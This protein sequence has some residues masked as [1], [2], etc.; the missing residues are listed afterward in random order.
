[1]QARNGRVLS[2]D[3]EAYY[4]NELIV[5]SAQTGAL[6][7]L[8]ERW[9]GTGQGAWAFLGENETL[10]LTLIVIGELP[11]IA[12]RLRERPEL[13][14][15][16]QQASERIYPGEQVKDLDLLLHA[17]R[18]EWPDFIVGKHRL[19]SSVGG[20]PYTGGTGTVPVDKGA[21]VE[22]PARKPVVG[23][24]L[25]IGILD[26]PIGNHAGLAGRYLADEEDLLADQNPQPMLAGHAMAVAGIVASRAPEAELIVHAAL[27][28]TGINASS[29][30]VAT[31]MMRFLDE[32]AEVVNLSFAGYTADDEPPLVIDR[33]VE[34]LMNKIVLVAAVGNFG[35]A[36]IP[37]EGK[38][39]AVSRRSKAFPAGC[40][41]VLGVGAATQGV[42]SVFSPDVPWV[43]LVAPGEDIDCLYLTGRVALGDGTVE[44]FTGYATW[45]GTSFAAAAVSGAIADLARSLKVPVG[46]ARDLLLRRS[47]A[48]LG[49]EHHQ[50]VRPPKLG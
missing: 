2:T 48:Q 36:P 7:D 40:V 45:S 12:I 13:V 22:I 33:A 1:M 49:P 5:D 16:A 29:W 37:A 30:D 19:L 35:E 32:G 18:E 23:R 17:L 43:S 14:A 15:K 31:R 26:T 46:K 38:P 39:P 6:V 25:R 42:R 27:D 34:R 9:A 50:D 3:I 47:A 21:T 41:G 20:Q 11:R 44:T 28:E 10:G 8:I 24:R 4:D